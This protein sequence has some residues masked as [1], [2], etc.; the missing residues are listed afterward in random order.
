ME[1]CRLPAYELLL[2]AHRVA[3]ESQN[4]IAVCRPAVDLE[5]QRTAYDAGYGVVVVETRPVVMAAQRRRYIVRA[6][7]RRYLAAVG[8]VVRQRIVAYGDDTA[9]VWRSG[10]YRIRP[11]QIFATHRT[12]G[13]LH[14]RPRLKPD[15]TVSAGIGK[16]AAVV[17]PQLPE[18]GAGALRPC[19]LV[20][21]GHD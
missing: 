19:R 18:A 8:Y 15:E 1:L 11:V 3:R 16:G 17:P 6:E 5:H 10:H 13:H 2:H 21:S 20:V 7:H 4:G 12:V 14:E 9:A